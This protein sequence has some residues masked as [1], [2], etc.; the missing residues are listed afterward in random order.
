MRLTPALLH[1]LLV[2]GLVSPS[3]SSPVFFVFGFDPPVAGF[4]FDPPAA[5]F[6][7]VGFGGGF[8]GFGGG[9]GGVSGTLVAI[10]SSSSS[11]VA[12]AALFCFS[13]FDLGFGAGGMFSYLF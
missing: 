7:F 8:V 10:G 13:F 3:L 4:G 2:A 11:A 5:G 6:G 12:E 1:N 9:G